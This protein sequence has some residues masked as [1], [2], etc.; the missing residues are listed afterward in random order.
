MK[1]GLLRSAALRL[2]AG[3]RVR[4]SSPGGAVGRVCLFKPDGIGDFVLSLGALRLLA[5]HH[6][7]ANCEIVVSSPVADLARAEFPLAR[8][9]SLPLIG[10]SRG[11]ER[12]VRGWFKWR[13]CLSTHTADMIFCLRHHRNLEEE[14]AL[15][16]M[17]ARQVVGL[18]NSTQGIAAADQAALPP[19]LTASAPR[20][21]RSDLA[22]CLELE[23][24]RQLLRLALSREIATDELLPR[25]VSASPTP[26]SA[27]LLAPF[28]SSVFKD[29]PNPQ[30]VE[31]VAQLL[32]RIR[33]PLQLAGS[34]GDRPRL[35]ELR[36]LVE[37]RCGVPLELL[38]AG[39]VVEF[40]RAIARARAVLTVDTAA[41]HLA[42]ALDKP[43]VV[44]HNGVHFG[45][46]GPW[47]RSERQRWLVHPL[48]CFGCGG[49]CPY[50]QPECIHRVEPRTVADA[51]V[52]VMG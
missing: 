33:V 3:A 14:C 42:T 16:W 7:E 31:A 34:P 50:P 29:Y 46:F 24:H 8:I 36:H 35:E 52:A 11:L 49:S 22:L 21:V 6:G 38:P 47:C 2:L 28:S 44:I 13:Q 12:V 25:L 43:T 40:A 41:A 45:M 1:P 39:S 30:M 19:T 4:R 48:D 32:A 10:A 9:L 20:P 51:L 15:L 26:G 23:S 17:N 18:T 27:L 5:A 37:S